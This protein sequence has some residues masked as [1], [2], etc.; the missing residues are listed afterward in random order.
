MVLSEL[1]EGLSYAE[2]T[3]KFI[4]LMVVVVSLIAMLIALMTTLNERRREMA[5]LRAIGAKSNQIIGLLVFESALLSAIGT[6]L[7]CSLA[8]IL[9]QIL[10]PVLEAKFGIY[11]GE[12]RIASNELYYIIGVFLVGTL[13]GFIPALRAKRRALKDGL[14]INV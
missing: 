10:K 3:L 11:F 6:L 13:I 4:T 9:T 5:I 14:S 2:G 8:F 12:S 1:W 7:G